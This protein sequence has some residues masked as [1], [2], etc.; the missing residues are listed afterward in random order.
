MYFGG[1]AFTS[2]IATMATMPFTIMTFNQFTLMSIFA[3][4]LAVPLTAFFVMPSALLTLLSMLFGLEDYTLPLLGSSIEILQHIAQY[5]STVPGSQILV[6]SPSPLSFYFIVFG[7]L[8]FCLWSQSWRYFCVVPVLLG[9]VLLV[10]T[11]QPHILIDG[12]GKLVAIR[13]DDGH[14]YVTSKRR[15]K[16]QREMWLRSLGES[17]VNLMPCQGSLC[18]MTVQGKI[19]QVMTN[20]EIHQ[21]AHDL[22][23]NLSDHPCS[24]GKNCISREDL[25]RDGAHAVYINEDGTTSI[26]TD[27]TV[28]RF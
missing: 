20:V 27:S 3:N 6:P 5:A 11:P 25:I 18:E 13:G 1:V 24:S 9:A 17:T 2:L 21:H 22:L 16:F 7:G 8:W 12:Q 4:M 23:I 10:L 14:I 28:N 26:R 19:I 15:G